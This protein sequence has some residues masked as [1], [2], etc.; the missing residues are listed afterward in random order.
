VTYL[1][2]AL[3]CSAFSPARCEVNGHRLAGRV[4]VV[5]SFADVKVREVSGVA[6]LRVRKVDA[7]PKACGEW[8]FVDSLPDFTIQFVDTFEDVSIRYVDAFPGR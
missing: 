5:S 6:D 1:F 4:E 2:I 8:Q 3:L 7:F